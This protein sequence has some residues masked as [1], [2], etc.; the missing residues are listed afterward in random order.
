MQY[1]ISRSF[2]CCLKKRRDQL[3]NILFII[4]NLIKK[5]RHI[6]LPFSWHVT[7][8]GIRVH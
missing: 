7:V 8:L 2:L 4:Y 1:Q 3:A 6:A 5:N